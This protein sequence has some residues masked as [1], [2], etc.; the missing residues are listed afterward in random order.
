VLITRGAGQASERESERASPCCV[1]GV[2]LSFC[3]CSRLR[4]RRLCFVRFN[5]M[6]MCRRLFEAPG[7]ELSCCLSH[8]PVS[9]IKPRRWHLGGRRCA[10]RKLL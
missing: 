3:T 2:A 5:G 4:R 8:F 9:C 6:H 10:A 7:P 1:I